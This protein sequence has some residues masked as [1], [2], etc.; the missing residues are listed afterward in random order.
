MAVKYIPGIGDISGKTIPELKELLKKP[1]HPLAKNQLQEAIAER[2]NEIR[3]LLADDELSRD[4]VVPQKT[5]HSISEDDDM[6]MERSIDDKEYVDG[7]EV[8]VPGPDEDAIVGESEEYYE[9][10]ANEQLE[11]I[12]R[13]EAEAQE[14]AK[15]KAEKRAKQRAKDKENQK[16][17][18]AER[19]RLAAEQAA[20]EAQQN[21]GNSTPESVIESN[22]IDASGNVVDAYDDVRQ[23]GS[24]NLNPEVGTDHSDFVP[25]TPAGSSPTSDPSQPRNVNEPSSHVAPIGVVDYEDTVSTDYSRDHQMQRQEQYQNRVDEVT[26][27][28]T[29]VPAPDYNPVKDDI[30]PVGVGHV[31]EQAPIETV[32]HTVRQDEAVRGSHINADELRDEIDSA[33][34]SRNH[35]YEQGNNHTSRVVSEQERAY[36]HF[37]EAGAVPKSVAA[38]FATY[39]GVSAD[40]GKNPHD[41]VSGWSQVDAAKVVLNNYHEETNII[42][43]KIVNLNQTVSDYENRLVQGK[44]KLSDA[45][46]AQINNSIKSTKMEIGRQQERLTEIQTDTVR[47]ND[48]INHGPVKPSGKSQDIIKSRINKDEIL[49]SDYSRRHR[50]ERND[51][52][53]NDRLANKVLPPNPGMEGK[54][55]FLTSAADM[56]GIHRARMS[57]VMEHAGGSVMRG[58]FHSVKR[59]AAED[60]D[61]NSVE[62]GADTASDVVRIHGQFV[63]YTRM[64][65][66]LKKL[67]LDAKSFARE[68][69][70]MGV[71]PGVGDVSKM[72]LKQLNEALK[73][74][75]SQSTREKVLRAIELKTKASASSFKLADDA[76]KRAGE[77]GSWSLKQIKKR[78][79]NPHLSVVDK[80]KLQAALEY[81]KLSKFRH[82]AGARWKTT[83]RFFGGLLTQMM[84]KSDVLADAI[85][86]ANTARTAYKVITV[87]AKVIAKGG[88]L[89]INTTKAAAKTTTK[90][91][92][93]TYNGVKKVSGTLAKSHS[94]VKAADT[95]KRLTSL[96]GSSKSAAAANGASKFAQSKFGQAISA[97]AARAKAAISAAGKAIASAVSSVIGAIA[98]AIG[99]GTLGI[100]IVVVVMILIVMMPV[101][102]ILG[103]D[104][105]GTSVP[106]MVEYLN[107]KNADWLAEI[108]EK[109]ES[110]PS[111]KDKNNQTMDEYTKVTYTYLDENGDVC[112]VTDNTK[113][114]ISMAAVYFEQDFSDEDKVFEYLDK[115]WDASHSVTYT[116]SPLYG[117]DG[118]VCL[119]EDGS[120]NTDAVGYNGTTHT[121]DCR[122]DVNK[123]EMETGSMYPNAFSIPGE[124][125]KRIDKM[126]ASARFSPVS[127]NSTKYA[128]I[129]PYTTDSYLGYGCKTHTEH[130][131]CTEMTSYNGEQKVALVNATNRSYQ[132]LTMDGGCRKKHTGRFAYE[133]IPS[134][135]RDYVENPSSL[136]YVTYAYDLGSNPVFEWDSGRQVYSFTKDGTTYSFTGIGSG[137]GGKWEGADSIRL[138]FNG[139]SGSSYKYSFYVYYSCQEMTCPG[140]DVSTHYCSADH[141][142]KMCEGHVDLKINISVVGFDKLYELEV[143]DLPYADRGEHGGEV[144]TSNICTH[145]N[146]TV[147]STNANGDTTSWTCNDCGVT[148]TQGVGYICTHSNQTINE[149]DASGTA[150]KWTCNGCGVIWISGVGYDYSNVGDGYHREEESGNQV[151]NMNVW[152]ETEREWVK[153]LFEQDWYDVYGVTVSSSLYIGQ[154][155]VGTTIMPNHPNSLP[156]PLFNQGD[157]PHAPYGEYGTVASHG[158]G[159]TCVAMLNSYYADQTI[160]PAFLARMFGHYNT[161]DGSYHSLFADSARQ[162]NL[163]F[164]KETSSW[165]EVVRALQDGKPVV[166]IQHGG[167]FTSGGHFI[168]LTG[169]TPDG[170][171]LVN[172][173]NGGNYNK[174]AT[175]IEG[176]ANGF[177]QTQIQAA[178]STYWIYGVKPAPTAE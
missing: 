160:S 41:N 112:M 5:T 49:N 110:R 72:S 73:G 166:S 170:R 36:Y 64:N 172:D 32:S 3:E 157:Y 14:K 39:G 10:L 148:W 6:D 43:H 153:G 50:I 69:K 107:E 124:K 45:E 143:T 12:E 118:T 129:Y 149:T 52:I 150:T 111:I 117:C 21:N 106:E 79:K 125:Q 122:E 133:D 168:L 162:L 46:V 177:T 171:I 8:F 151:L 126:W 99:G 167:I 58:F 102:L 144:D 121:Y 20:L 62:R 80:Q 159:I 44:G 123:L 78:L 27:M 104:S 115:M 146:Q 164:D 127:I 95:G 63:A 147:Q 139:M 98:G 176:F 173:P 120:L 53:G 132:L 103:D 158:C 152:T 75:L 23:Q 88:G 100:A 65:H 155:G 96:L 141:Q 84:Q 138:K 131:K 11:E 42:N 154:D 87:G 89:V 66:E 91:V 13:L 169:I 30:T 137:S 174:N 178:G 55:N 48:F 108:N 38:Q 40:I 76:L 163:P 161:P 56:K 61:I 156:I 82:M 67:G 119:K 9:D 34:Y 1:L 134:G 114:L 77:Y 135:C 93:S 83:G 145:S 113:H 70:E 31:P 128:G 60:D 28:P 35:Q 16:R 37:D 68:L 92:K 142:E 22:V 97:A 130:L 86:L 26:P 17:A 101:M 2:E 71:V 18:Q 94:T 24:V 25:E 33:D 4:K 175:M 85:G 7:E 90:L 57:L 29:P 140:H 51:V 54:G 19:D 81:H 15:R 105:N 74:N 47:V 116:E 109:A 165:S 59:V 136:Y